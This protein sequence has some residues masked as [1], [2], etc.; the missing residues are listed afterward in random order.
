MKIFC[1]VFTLFIILF[2]SSS[3][4]DQPATKISGYM[5]GDYYY[6][7]ERDTSI[8]S[9]SNLALSGAKDQNGFQFRRI[10]LTFDN[11]ISGTFSTRFRIEGTTGAPVIKDAYLKWK[12]IFTGSD[13]LVGLQPTP[14]FEVSESYWKYR[15]IEK[16]IL[17]LR[18]VV[19]SRDLGVSLKGSLLSG[20]SV[21]YWMMFGNNSGTGAET[22]KYKRLYAHLDLMPAKNFRVTIYA[23]YKMQPNINDPTSTTAPKRTLKNNTLNTSLFAGYAED[24]IFSIG[25]EAY[26][27]HQSYGYIHGT[28]PVSVDDKN[29]I[30]LSLFGNYSVTPEW[31]LIGRFDHSDINAASDALHD[32]RDYFLAGASWAAEKNVSIIPNILVE[33]YESVLSGAGT[34]SIDPSITARITFHYVFL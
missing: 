10:Y 33:T 14:A 26:L 32:V 22:D 16:S 19:S 29:G 20:G 34:R 31:T 11:T 23:D 3:A 17:D 28:L 6:H 27:Q 5:F 2:Q 7:I 9:M 8:T 24:G 25:T 4:Q 1:T 18:G 21:N 13:L 30:G 15:S 12:G